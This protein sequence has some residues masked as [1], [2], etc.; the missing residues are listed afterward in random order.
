MAAHQRTA[1][2]AQLLTGHIIGKRWGGKL[3]RYL[4]IGQTSRGKLLTLRLHV[5]PPT[6]ESFWWSDSDHLPK[7]YFLVTDPVDK[8]LPPNVAAIFPQKDVL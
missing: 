8:L 6:T 1:V 5:D 7:T 3:N 2:V 4:V